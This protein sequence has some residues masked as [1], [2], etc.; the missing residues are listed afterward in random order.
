MVTMVAYPHRLRYTHKIY[1]QK[2]IN[3]IFEGLVAS[4]MAI[5]GHPAINFKIAITSDGICRI[6]IVGSLDGVPITERISFSEAGTTYSQNTF[7]ELT[8]ITSGYFVS[9][10]T[11]SI[12]AVDDVGMPITWSQE[13]GPYKAEFGQMG[14]M[15]AQLEAN[16]LGLGSK[17]VHYVRC[18]RATLLSK[19]MTMSVVGYD[20]QLFVPICD[21]ENISA[22][23]NYVAQEWAFRVVKKQDGDD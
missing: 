20:D 1:I 15:S 10:T 2:D 6:K 18:E 9:G 16:S 3:E 14:G 22:P 7:D 5:V 11:V 13:Y 4:S 17:I 19:D 12:Q 23:P 8:T 21:F